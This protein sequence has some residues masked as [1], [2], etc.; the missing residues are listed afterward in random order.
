M[1]TGR[2]SVRSD[3]DGRVEARVAIGFSPVGHSSL[4]GQHWVALLALGH[5]DGER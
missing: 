5:G 1:V 3:L 4:C 2:A